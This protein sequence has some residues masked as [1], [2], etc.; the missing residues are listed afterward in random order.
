MSGFLSSPS[1]GNVT[2]RDVMTLMKK[3]Q[4]LLCRYYIHKESSSILVCLD[5]K[6]AGVSCRNTNSVFISP[7]NGRHLML[8]PMLPAITISRVPMLCISD[9]S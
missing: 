1:F 4:L 5:S 2:R 9:G 7:I 8:Q 3:F 6:V